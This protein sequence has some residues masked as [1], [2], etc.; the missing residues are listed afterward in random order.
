MSSVIK[1]RVADDYMQSIMDMVEGK[2]ASASQTLDRRSFLK[3]TGMAGGGLVLAFHV[4]DKN[5]ALANTDAVGTFA[6]N[7]YVR[8][9]K[10][11]AITIFAKNPEIG[12][13]VK[14]SLPMIVAEELDA[15]WSKV[16]CVQSAISSAYGQQMAGGSRSIPSNWDVLRKAGATAR[17]MLVSAA[18]QKWNVPAAEL[19]TDKSV[20]THPASKKRA[21][22]GELAD[23]AATL[24]V[25]A[26]GSVT[27]KT[28][29]QYKLLG[30]RIGGVDN[31]DIVTG[32]PLFGID[33]QLPGMVYAAFERCPAHGGKVKSANIEDIKKLPGVKDCFVVEGTPEATS[34]FPGVAIVATSTWAAF[35]AKKMLRVEWDETAAAKDSW[36]SIIAQAK[37][38]AKQQGSKKVKDTGNVDEA[39][40]SAK[41]VV[42]GLY[43]YPFVSHSPL[44]PMN[45]TANYKDGAIEFWAPTQMPTNAIPLVSKTLGIPADKVTINQTRIGGGFGRRLMN[46]Y[47]CEVGQIA[48]RVNGPVKLVW[49]REDDMTHDFYRPGGFHSFKGAIDANG[50]ISAWQDHFI[51]FSSGGRPVSGGAMQGNEVPAPFVPNFRL[52]QTELPLNQPC[53]PWRAPGSNSFAFVTQCFIHELATAAGRDHRDVLLEMF[54]EPRQLAANEGGLHTGRAAAVI[55]LATEKAGWGRKMPEGHGLGLAFYYSH[56]G[57][58]AEVAEVSVDKNKKVTLHKVIVAGDIGQIVNM[59]GAENQAQGCVIDG[60]STMAR[61][62]IGFENGRVEQNNFHQYP[63]LRIG[64]EPV[65]EAHFIQSDF[66]P[67][68]VGEPALPP[69]IPAVANAIFAATGQRVRTLPLTR[70]GFSI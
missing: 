2:A 44:E 65:V 62:E 14:T 61:L 30:S 36:N 45:C 64:I 10:D 69:L 24:P 60:F 22:Y 52:T 38:L 40:T 57:H 48:K 66:S 9:T 47:M 41:K 29:A 11:N 34:G 46:D 67:T 59:S 21:T 68:G 54:G 58:F 12:Q 31:K 1:N 37:D 4:G 13:G 26:E 19:T 55:K 6:P 43:T 23:L 8:I 20:V 16:T 33:Q 25:P 15:D 18:A 5:I 70:E 42:E 7:A 32:K 39:F 56:A 53:G 27:L 50:K 51:T 3:L 28:R 49:T 35:K 17:S 63:L